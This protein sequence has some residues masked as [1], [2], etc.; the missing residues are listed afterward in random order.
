MK[1]E[2]TKSLEDYLKNDDVNFDAYK[3]K[4]DIQGD[5]EPFHVY[6][7]N[8]IAKKKVEAF[9]IEKKAY[10][11]KQIFKRADIKESYGYKLLNGSGSLGNKRDIVIRIAFAADFTVDEVNRALKCA[12]FRPLYVKD[13][14]DA[15]IYKVFAT[16]INCRDVY[17]LDELLEANGFEKLESVGMD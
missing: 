14:R 5:L 6:A 8:I 2:D 3:N 4:F 15:F 16:R 11:K 7:S 17:E 10:E 13:L 12:G 9:G 1:E